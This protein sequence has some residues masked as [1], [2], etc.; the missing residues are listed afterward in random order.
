MYMHVYG[1]I[2]I[3]VFVYIYIYIYLYIYIYVL[4]FILAIGY[5][6]CL[7]HWIGYDWTPFLSPDGSG[8]ELR[9]KLDDFPNVFSL[10]VCLVCRT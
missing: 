6:I 2:Y 7:I 10:P 5:K 1:Y 9:T 8:R 4:L 3:F